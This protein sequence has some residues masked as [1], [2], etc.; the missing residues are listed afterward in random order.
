M[1][2]LNSYDT[3]VESAYIIT[4]PGEE[5]SEK[6]TQQ[7]VASCEAV[8]Q[9][10]KLW[11]GFNG[12]S[13]EIK[14]PKHLEGQAFV[15]FLRLHT[16]L[17]TPTQI[18]C[19]YSHYSLWCMCVDID[20]PIVILE[21]DA[22]ME[23]PYLHHKFHNNIVYLGSS[24]QKFKDWEIISIPPHATDQNGLYRFICRAHAYAIDPFVAKNMISYVIQQGITTTLDVILRSDIIP[25]VQDG[26]YAYDNNHGLSTIHK[27]WV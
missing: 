6:L 5:I 12:R 9:P 15:N 20:R 14:V 27:E 18:A 1:N 19:F 10:Y 17:M 7:C 8:G 25:I 21:H 23:R 26:L 4:L 13:G 2:Y 24:E 3:N 11:E 22:V 16:Q